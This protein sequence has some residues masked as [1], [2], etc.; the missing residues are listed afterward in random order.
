MTEDN[1][2]HSYYN[3][4]NNCIKMM[5]DRNYKVPDFPVLSMEQFKIMYETHSIDLYGILDTQGIPCYV[6]FIH[7]SNPFLTVPERDAVYASIIT[8]LNSNG[9]Q[10]GGFKKPVDLAESVDLKQGKIRLILVYKTGDKGASRYEK[11]YL[12]DPFVEVHQVKKLAIDIFACKY[13]PQYRMLSSKQEIDGILARY[14]GKPMM[15][16]S[17]T[18][19]DPVNRYFRG[20]PAENGNHPTIYEI[21]RKGVSVYYRKVVPKKMNL[22][23]ES[24]GD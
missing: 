5:K 2:Y 6:K 10:V 14:D 3:A 11:N 13:Q 8:T 21:I 1:I 20:R 16:G 4:R 19:D 24:K 18:I 15:L 17:I 23:Q 9:Y 12:M 22:K 7:H